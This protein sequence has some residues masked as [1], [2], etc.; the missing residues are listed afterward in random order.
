MSA[1]FTTHRFTVDEYHR[2]AAAGILR[3]DERVELLDGQ[4][5]P[6]T[7]IGPDHGSCVNRLTEMLAPLAGTV[8]TL[9]V[10]NPVV[11]GEHQEPQPDVALL[12]H[13]ADGYRERHPERPD[14]LLVIEVA[15]ATIERDRRF[16]IP[17]Y[18]RAAIAETWVVN[19]PVDRVEVY[20]V[21]V[22]GKYTSVTTHT[23]GET[24]TPGAFPD[25]A[26][27]VDRILG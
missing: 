15:D 17:V 11:L 4:V 19:L 16:K 7:P 10:H 6:M 12:R 2:M 5:V 22:G 13:R 9:S 25:F 26:L 23:R 27:R 8:A 18:A 20:R 24:L 21:P 1:P 3:P 14:V